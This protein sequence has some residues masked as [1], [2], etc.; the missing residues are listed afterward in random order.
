[1]CKILYKI[2]SC[3]LLLADVVTV[4]AKLAKRQHARAD[5]V[6]PVAN[7]IKLFFSHVVS[8]IS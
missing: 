7:S 8:Q 4:V 2:V 5:Y 6:E 3:V 1:M